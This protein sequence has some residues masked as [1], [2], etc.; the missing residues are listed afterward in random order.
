M[1]AQIISYN[2]RLNPY[3]NTVSQRL[4][5]DRRQLDT[6]AVL[7]ERSAELHREIESLYE[8]ATALLREDQVEEEMERW[9]FDAIFN[10][11]D[12]ADA[13]H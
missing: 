10:H 9:S 4:G 2:F 3:L 5:A 12:L 1:S 6:L 7:M 8:Q 11:Y 13:C